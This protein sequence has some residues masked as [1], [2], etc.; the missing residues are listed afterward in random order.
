MKNI[1]EELAQ[2]DL[3]I[4]K[5][6]RCRAIALEVALYSGMFLFCCYA[7]LVATN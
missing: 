1:N 7:W 4:K 6:R 2:L 3:D 5:Y